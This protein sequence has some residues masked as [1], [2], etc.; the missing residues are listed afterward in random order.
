MSETQSDKTTEFITADRLA[1]TSSKALTPRD[2]ARLADEIRGIAAKAKDRQAALI[3][4]MQGRINQL[5]ARPETSSTGI[6]DTYH[7]ALVHI[8]QAMAQLTNRIANPTDVPQLA[9]Q[10]PK[11]V[12]MQSDDQKPQQ[13]Y[14]ALTTGYENAL[15]ALAEG[16]EANPDKTANDQPAPAAEYNNKDISGD[17]T[18]QN[19]EPPSNA[20]EPWNEAAAEQLTLLYE[21]GEAGLPTSAPNHTAAA[22]AAGEYISRH[23]ADSGNKTAAS[24]PQVFEPSNTKSDR[25]DQQFANIQAALAQL[26]KEVSETSRNWLNGELSEM[27]SKVEASLHALRRTA[28][29]TEEVEERFGQ[30]ESNICKAIDKLDTKDVAAGLKEIET[31]IAAFSKY[32]EATQAEISRIGELEQNIQ[33][34]A[35]QLQDENIMRLASKLQ[36]Q[37][38]PDLNPENI[39]EMVADRVRERSKQDS[40]NVQPD[41][42]DNGTQKTQETLSD[43]QDLLNNLLLEQRSGDQ[44]TTD[45]LEAMQQNLQR[46]L[47]RVEKL[48]APQE[49]QPTPVANSKAATE[50]APE[51]TEQPQPQ[52]ELPQHAPYA[53]PPTQ[54]V[55]SETNS[56]AGT[57]VKPEDRNPVHIDS[58]HVADANEDQYAL[59]RANE[60]LQVLLKAN[61]GER[62]DADALQGEVPNGYVQKPSSGLLGSFGARLA[63]TVITVLAIGLSAGIILHD[64]HNSNAGKAD[65]HQGSQATSNEKPQISQNK[66]EQP[67]FMETARNAQFQHAIAT[68]QSDAG[69]PAGIILTI[70]EHMNSPTPSPKETRA[71]E[72]IKINPPQ[73][74]A[75]AIPTSLSPMERQGQHVSGHRISKR[76]LPP[77]LIGPLSL[78]IKA[79]DGDPSASFQVGAR[80]AEGKGIRQDFSQALTWYTRSATKGFPLAQYRLAALYERGMGTKADLAR[81]K[82]W[83]ERAARQGN[84]KAMHNLAVLL[85]SG[86]AGETDYSTAVEWFKQAAERG[87]TDSKFNLGILYEA[88]LGVSKDVTE[89]YKWFAL[90][91]RSGDKDADKRRRALIS[92]ID[93]RVLTK[94]DVAVTSWRD[95]STSR[96]ANDPFFAGNQWRMQST[97]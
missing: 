32:I 97:N 47:E 18:G 50:Q 40:S 21:N 55:F 48:E 19:P 20:D 56:T 92:K 77:A 95:R 58:A 15:K 6:P 87:L 46:V 49:D 3:P 52:Y 85:A 9:S 23:D 16:V 81:A 11:E 80:F 43:L 35:E 29:A 68:N 31:N 37:S 51:Q 4:G 1:A 67:I 75:K 94:T 64:W 62:E 10:Q 79:A 53:A 8:E 83:Y 82:V 42:S 27:T 93:K 66:A 88:G 17:L 13:R 30:L 24:A 36:P 86:T 28:P 78:R 12:L 73:P 89:A 72:K 65:V 26:P 45:R 38:Q 22:D 74:A 5:S 44:Q 39:A 33:A 91:A 76:N 34:L 54:P 63:I 84:V 96:L 57:P 60:R 7:D 14:T 61:H 69:L 59:D 25:L 70:P 41:Q 90:A 71:Q 2:L